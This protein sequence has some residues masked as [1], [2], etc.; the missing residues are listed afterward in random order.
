LRKKIEADPGRPELLITEPS[1]GYR[2][3]IKK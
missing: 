3:V 1:I 2:L